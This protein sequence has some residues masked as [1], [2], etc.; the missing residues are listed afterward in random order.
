[1]SNFKQEILVL[2]PDNKKLSH[3]QIYLQCPFFDTV[4]LFR[5]ANDTFLPKICKLI[6][7]R[8]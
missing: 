8:T 1:M 6:V 2:N 4:V 3:L 7:E 5:V